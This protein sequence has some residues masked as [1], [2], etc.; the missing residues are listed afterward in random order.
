ME[1]AI[2]SEIALPLKDFLLLCKISR[3]LDQRPQ[4]ISTPTGLSGGNPQ[5]TQ[6]YNTSPVEFSIGGLKRSNFG[7]DLECGS[8]MSGGTNPATLPYF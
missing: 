3:L 6:K 7:F 8:C 1:A 4:L 2:S 5:R